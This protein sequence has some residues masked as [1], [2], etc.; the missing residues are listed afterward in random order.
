LHGELLEIRDN[1]L[2]IGLLDVLRLIR[3]H[4]ILGFHLDRKAGMFTNGTY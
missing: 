4:D 3:Y 2:L 1:G